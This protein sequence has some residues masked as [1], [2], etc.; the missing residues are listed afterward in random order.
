M[1]TFKDSVLNFATFFKL[2]MVLLWV[3]TPC[4][5]G[6]GLLRLPQMRE[7]PKN[8]SIG[9]RVD[10]LKGEGLEDLGNSDDCLKL[11]GLRL[12]YEHLN[13]NTFG[14]RMTLNPFLVRNAALRSSPLT[15]APQSDPLIFMED[16][17]F[18]YGPIPHLE[19]GVENYHGFFS[20][21][22]GQLAF[23]SSFY[24]TSWD[25][26]ALSVALNLAALEDLSFKLI[27]GNGEGELPANQNSQGFVGAE[28]I[29]RF[30]KTLT[31]SGGVSFNGN[32]AA[33]L[34]WEA[35]KDAMQKLCGVMR[36]SAK[37]T[38][39]QR[40]IMAGLMFE[41]TQ[42]ILPG[43]ISGIG[44]QQSVQK[45][46]SR[47]EDS[48]ISANDLGQCSRLDE[49][50]FFLED[51]KHETENIFEKQT[52][53]FNVSYRFFERFLVS[54][55]LEQR[56]TESDL[57]AFT[58][59]LTVGDSQCAKVGDAELTLSQRAYTVGFGVDVHEGLRLLLEFNQR[60]YDQDYEKFFYLSDSGPVRSRQR[61]NARIAY[62]WD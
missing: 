61:F 6:F 17:Y 37:H 58:T 21:P 14:S 1:M 28:G 2:F 44:W 20:P 42:N 32:Q 51:V 52:I 40:R 29:A 50:L 36:N 55:D 39:S 18:I 3:Y 7:K 26:L 16:F 22:R 54:A 41:G 43:F 10:C 15:K 62:Q 33:S 19:L 4:L 35:E 23:G 53:N 57:P 46:L 8:F 59:C 31:L 9:L 5:N 49:D 30:L 34:R 24:D 47:E 25:Q 56:G 60:S 12:T 27:V 11:S 48:F 38:Y 45:D 13:Q